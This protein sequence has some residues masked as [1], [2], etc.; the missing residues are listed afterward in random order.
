MLAATAEETRVPLKP[1]GERVLGWPPPHTLNNVLWTLSQ[2][3]GDETQ[4]TAEQGGSED[5][6]LPRKAKL[7]CK[8]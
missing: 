8:S 2:D 5:T 3:G 6:K 7:F 4:V 1:R